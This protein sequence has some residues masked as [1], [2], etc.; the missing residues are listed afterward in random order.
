M[1]PTTAA[2]VKR[3]GSVVTAGSKSRKCEHSGLI[4]VRKTHSNSAMWLIRI[5]WVTPTTKTKSSPRGRPSF[6]FDR[7]FRLSVA[8]ARVIK[9]IRLLLIHPRGIA[10]IINFSRE[11]R[12]K[13]QFII[14]FQMLGS[15][16]SRLR[17]T[18]LM[19]QIA[20]V[21]DRILNH[22][23]QHFMMDLKNLSPLC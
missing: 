18:I 17:A 2:K 21:W 3:I 22:S 14:H 5:A 20:R 23:S 6:T 13:E 16:I 10:R 11:L 12:S 7:S 4:K 15:L 9:M 19:T 1:M 8:R